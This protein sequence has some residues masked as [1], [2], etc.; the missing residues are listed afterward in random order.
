MAQ[1]RQVQDKRKP[2]AAVVQQPDNKPDD[3]P[4]A[5]DAEPQ[6][7]VTFDE[8]QQL[9]IKEIFNRRFGKIKS[10]H[11]AALAAAI[12]AKDAELA[13]LRGELDQLKQGDYSAIQKERDEAQAKASSAEAQMQE[14]RKEHAMHRAMTSIE[15]KFVDLRAAYE[16]T[17]D[18]VAWSEELNQFAVVDADGQPVRNS[19]LEPM[20]LQEFYTVFAIKH[21][22]L[23]RGDLVPGAGSSESQFRSG[24]RTVYARFKSDLKTVAEKSAFVDK[25]G[26]EAWDKLPLKPPSEQ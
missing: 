2:A 18:H 10:E 13:G 8:R 22:Y 9:K 24:S 15:S 20:T 12:A 5:P 4:D 23:V 16:L 11:E 7:E 14:M 19:H 6:D 1:K 26:Y 21:P 3:R 17:K 25:Y